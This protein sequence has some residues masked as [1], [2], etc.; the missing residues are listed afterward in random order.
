MKS[1]RHTIKLSDRA[2]EMKLFFFKSSND[3]KRTIE[4]KNWRDLTTSEE[5]EVVYIELASSGEKSLRT[6]DSIIKVSI[7]R[8]MTAAYRGGLK[9]KDI[10]VCIATTSMKIKWKERADWSVSNIVE[11]CSFWKAGQHKKLSAAANGASQP[12]AAAAI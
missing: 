3:I 6:I 12:A 4:K 5:L 11:P 9:K 7:E 2:D 8:A 1:F 10:E